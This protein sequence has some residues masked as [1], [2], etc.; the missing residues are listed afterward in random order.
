MSSMEIAKI[1]Y[2]HA[3]HDDSARKNETTLSGEGKF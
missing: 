3:I 1:R 2:V